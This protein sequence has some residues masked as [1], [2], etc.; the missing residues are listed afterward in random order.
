MRT[1][2]S[3]LPSVTL[4]VGLGGFVDGILFHQ[5][6]QWHHVVSDV[7]C[8]PAN[9][10][11]GLEGDVLADGIFHAVVWLVTLGG[12]LTAI[13]SWRRGLVPPWGTHLGG[14]LIGW[15]AFNLIDSA[16]HFILG[17]HH[18]R[19]DLGGPIGWDIGFLVFAVALLA[20]GAATV[21]TSRRRTGEVKAAEEGRGV[22]S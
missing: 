12:T 19:D 20:A 22:H 4:G 5:I 9:S 17:L 3:I 1:R 14:L 7:G 8:C 21:R 13:H 2:P 15:G 6:L 18:V 11:A 16:N 10:V